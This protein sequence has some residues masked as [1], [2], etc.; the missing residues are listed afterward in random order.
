MAL[1]DRVTR[2]ERLAPPPP[3]VLGAFCRCPTG[4]LLIVHAGAPDDQSERCAECDRPRIRVRLVPAPPT[5][6]A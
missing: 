3:E 4:G 5:A 6:R 2:L 1:R